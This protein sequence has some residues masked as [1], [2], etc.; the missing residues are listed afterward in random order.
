MKTILKVIIRLLIVLVLLIVIPIG[1]LYFMI[2]DSKDEAPTELYAENITLQGEID[3]LFSRFLVNREGAF[4]LTFSEEELDKLAF[5]FIR[6]I[7]SS[8][9]AGCGS[10]EC[11]YIV[12]QEIPEEVPLISGKKSPPAPSLHGSGIR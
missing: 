12:S 3:S 6:S 10:D 11:K 5:A 8:Y 2:S 4:Y 9:Y 1:T 7:N